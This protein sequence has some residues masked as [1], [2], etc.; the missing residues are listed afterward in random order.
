VSTTRETYYRTLYW[1]AAA[2]DIA[3]GVAFLF[4]YHQIARALDFEAELPEYGGYAALIAAFVFVIG[5][6]YVF[7]ARGDLVR[8]IDL[9]A[10]G[11]IYKLAYTLVAVYFFARDDYPH[12]IFVGFGVA[13]FIFLVLMAECWWFLRSLDTGWSRTESS[14]G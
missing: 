13:D 11:T 14:A 1:V 4:F 9:I 12:A 6:G 10:V 2:Y 8:N 3:L 7:V 5:V